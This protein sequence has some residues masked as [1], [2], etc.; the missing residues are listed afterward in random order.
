MVF[1][2][3]FWDDDSF[4]TLGDKSYLPE[5][6]FL[7]RAILSM[8]SLLHVP[9]LLRACEKNTVHPASHNLHTANKLCAIWGS[10]NAFLAAFGSLSI[11]NSN[12]S[13]INS[14]CL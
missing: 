11:I 7:C 8:V 4:S 9:L 10:L 12:V 5:P 3:V 2:G 14:S 6:R 1:F 13:V